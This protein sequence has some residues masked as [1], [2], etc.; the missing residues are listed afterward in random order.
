M[1]VY[2]CMNAQCCSDHSHLPNP[3]FF[4]TANGVHT[5]QKSCNFSKLFLDK[6]HRV[7]SFKLIKP[8]LFTGLRHMIVNSLQTTKEGRI[9]GHGPELTKVH[10]EPNTKNVC[11]KATARE[12]TAK[13]DQE[14]SPLQKV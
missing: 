8:D 3:T 2:R 6:R 10:T 9:H 12:Q 4:D 7:P 11:R 1:L 14:V 13:V 5:K